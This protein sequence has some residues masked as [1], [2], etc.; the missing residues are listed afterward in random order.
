MNV[1]FLK[2]N[3]FT[4]DGSR[5]Q[6]PGRECDGTILHQVELEDILKYCNRLPQSGKKHQDGA[7]FPYINKTLGEKTWEVK[8]GMTDGVIFVDIDHITKETAEIIF[9]SFEKIS[10]LFPCLYAIQYSSSYFIKE[11]NA[12]LHCFVRSEILDKN[13]Y[14]RFAAICLAIFAHVTQKVTGIDLREPQTDDEVILDTHN[15]NI[16]QRFFLYYSPYKVNQYASFFTENTVDKKTINT[17]S[18]IYPFLKRINVISCGDKVA[19]TSNYI[20]SGDVSSKIKLDF[21]KECIISNF[22]SGVGYD[23]QKI[24]A[25]LLAIDNRDDSEYV[26]K[27]NQ[28]RANHFEQIARTSKGRSVYEWQRKAAIEI[29]EKCGISIEFDSISSGIYNIKRNH[30]ITDFK[31]EIVDYINNHDKVEIL[32][33]TGTGKTTLINGGKSAKEADLFDPSIIEEFSLAKELNAVVIVPFNVTNKLYNKLHEVSSENHNKVLENVPNVMVWDQA[34]K[35]WSEIKDRTLIIDEAHTLFLD[36]TYRDVAVTLMNKIKNDNCKIVLMTATPSGEG[37]ELGVEYLRFANE[38]NN[39]KADFIKVNNVDVFQYKTIVRNL[40]NG[41]F[42][43]I[44]L[45]DDTTAKKIYEKIFCEGVY[46]NDVAYIRSDTKDQEDFRNLRDSE[47]LTKKLTICTCVAFNGLNFKNKGE[48]ILV[49]TSAS[50]GS[51][52][53]CEIIQEAGRIRNSDVYLTVCYDDKDRT[54]NLEQ[55]IRKAELFHSAEISMDIP[56][57]LLTY[58]DRLIDGEIQDALRRINA[59]VEK[60]SDIDVIINDLVDAGYFVITKKDFSDDERESGNKMSLNLKKRESDSLKEDIMDGTVLEKSYET[61]GNNKYKFD[62]Q[63]QISQMIDNNGY[64]GITIETFQNL[65]NNTNGCTLISTIISNLKRAV[66]VALIPDDQWNN[67]I[68]NIEKVKLMLG[69]DKVAI[70]KLSSSYKKN[71]EIRNKY[72][73]TITV[74]NDM[75]DMSVF[76]D[77]FLQEFI[78]G[79]NREKMSKSEAGKKASKEDKILAGGM[80]GKLGSPKKKVLDVETGIEYNSCEDCALAIGKSNSYISKHK[81]RF[82]T[83]K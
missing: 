20:V 19:D 69:A 39:V 22:L 57:G 71:V 59:Y 34:I 40:E 15:S 63:R 48:R 68:S 27:H 38:R 76:C 8:E 80:G 18:T 1:S 16:T 21:N 5:R 32:A 50:K 70:S 78:E 26:K 36:R 12:G 53:S 42:D 74:K 7:I 73:G 30:Y 2:P 3:E 4:P 49:I 28:T 79:Y 55:N 81:D 51:T 67:Y 75:L 47:L 64:V 35:H 43:K 77:S 56:A 62:W 83:I 54:D 82:K 65:I 17:L 9:N 37:E 6:K 10:E 61:E 13:T 23:T 33:P 44:V 72:K 60:K 58:N 29:L 25:T 46:V 45:F 52:T 24:V 41:W 31:H 14:K 11:K 66:T